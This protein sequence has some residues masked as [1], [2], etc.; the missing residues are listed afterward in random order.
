MPLDERIGIFS[1]PL[2]TSLTA[3]CLATRCRQRMI[4]LTI[5]VPAT[6]VVTAQ[7]LVDLID[8]RPPHRKQ[9]P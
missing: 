9:A 7:S 3:T 5:A 8:V 2:I 6:T 1:P 4:A